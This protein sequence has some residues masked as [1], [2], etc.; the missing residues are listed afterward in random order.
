LL[1]F[2]G[3]KAALQLSIFNEKITAKKAPVKSTTEK[4]KF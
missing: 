2:L 1:F 3:G 4:S